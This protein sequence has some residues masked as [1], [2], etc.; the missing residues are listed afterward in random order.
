[1]NITNAIFDEIDVVVVESQIEV[2]E[3]MCQAYDKAYDILEYCTDEDADFN[4]FSIVQE[5]AVDADDDADEPDAEAKKKKKKDKKGKQENI[6]KRMLDAI[7]SFFKMIGN[8]VASLFKKVKEGVTDKLRKLGKKSDSECEKAQEKIDNSKAAEKI[9]QAADKFEKQ[10]EPIRAEDLT[11]GKSEGGKTEAKSE[12][13]EE[14]AE[15]KTKIIVKE[16]K[17]KTCIIFDN[18]ITFLEY[19]DAWSKRIIK[20]ASELS[21]KSETRSAIANRP[22]RA[23]QPKND[24]DLKNLEIDHTYKVV[25]SKWEDFKADFRGGKDVRKARLKKHKMFTIFRK[26]YPVSEVA[27]KIDKINELLKK[28]IESSKNAYEQ[29]D[30][31]KKM[32][33]GDSN[34]WLYKS[35][36]KDIVKIHTELANISSIVVALAK[37]IALELEL[38]DTMLKIIVP[39][40]DEAE[41]KRKDEEREEKTIYVKVD[42]SKDDKK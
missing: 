11:E 41:K 15:N 21:D 12:A 29:F 10:A 2:F 37:Y 27:D 33:A 28:N 1:M 18:W 42:T 35:L 32:T 25:Q 17:I 16:K 8:A 39:M 9:D 6:L 40:F 36:A 38:Y 5:A 4:M 7:V 3:A 34:D 30:K 20:N 22:S 24:H 13:K 23:I 31:L 26:K 19:A 14:K